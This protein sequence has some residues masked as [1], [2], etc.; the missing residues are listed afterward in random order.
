MRTRT[1]YSSIAAP[2][3]ITSALPKKETAAP[4]ATDAAASQTPCAHT[5]KGYSAV[6]TRA[7]RQFAASIKI[8]IIALASLVIATLY[9]P[10][11]P[12]EYLRLMGC[13]AIFIV[14]GSIA[15]WGET[16]PTSEVTQ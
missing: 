10:A 2:L 1:A 5:K 14:F 9:M 7:Q 16:R 12:S 6:L 4:V 11:V 15:L 3:R 13:L 8:A